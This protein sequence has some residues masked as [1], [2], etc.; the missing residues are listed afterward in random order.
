M[1]LNPFVESKGDV[2]PERIGE[3]GNAKRPGPVLN[4]FNDFVERLDKPL[5]HLTFLVAEGSNNA[6]LAHAGLDQP[7]NAT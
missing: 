7:I 2:I 6:G 4:T 5:A 3:N 1:G